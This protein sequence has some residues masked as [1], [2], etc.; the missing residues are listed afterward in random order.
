MENV[1]SVPGELAGSCNRA[2]GAGAG[3]ACIQLGLFRWEPEPRKEE[4]RQSAGPGRETSDL[5][6]G[7][8]ASLGHCLPPC[9]G[10]GRGF[11][12]LLLQFLKYKE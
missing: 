3:S 1:C 12:P 7:L 4:G 9:P 11:P 6:E 8:A 5:P 10:H 2:T